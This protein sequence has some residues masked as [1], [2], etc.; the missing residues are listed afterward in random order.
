[1]KQG[2][3]LICLVVSGLVF[4]CEH[5]NTTKKCVKCLR[6]NYLSYGK[7][8][9]T[10]TCGEANCTAPARSISHHKHCGKHG[11]VISLTQECK[12]CAIE[13]EK[14]HWREAHLAKEEGRE[15]E[16]LGIEIPEYRQSISPAQKLRKLQELQRMI[17]TVNKRIEKM[18]DRIFAPDVTDASIRWCES[19]IEELEYEKMIYIRAYR[20]WEDFQPSH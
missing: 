8:K 10:I 4:A 16:K 3:F 7:E 5:N 9:S 18:E 1:M 17:N 6:E 11:S 19:K 14:E 2:L 12:Q 15:F 13:E 20:I